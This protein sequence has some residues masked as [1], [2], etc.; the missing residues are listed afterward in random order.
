LRTDPTVETFMKVA[1][2]AAT[3]FVF[4]SPAFAAGSCSTAPQASWQPQSNLEAQLKSEGLTVRQI[5]VENG[6]FEVY[7]TD[8]AGKR[9]NLAYNAET[10]EKLDNAEAGEN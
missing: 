10:L 6:C 1:L 9:I 8:S 5:K 4:A 7:A 2:L 3:A